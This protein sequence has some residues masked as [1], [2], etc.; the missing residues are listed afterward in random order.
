MPLWPRVRVVVNRTEGYNRKL[1]LVEAPDEQLRP[2]VGAEA[3]SAVGRRFV[4]RYEIYARRYD[5]RLGGND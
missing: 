3:L 2:A 1:W 4:F 5:E